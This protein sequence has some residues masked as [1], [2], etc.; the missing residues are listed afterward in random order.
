MLSNILLTC[1]VS[2]KSW[3]ANNSTQSQKSFKFSIHLQQSIIKWKLSIWFLKASY[4]FIVDS[5]AW[6]SL[7]CFSKKFI[8]IELNVELI[9]KSMI[10]MSWFQDSSKVTTTWRDVNWLSIQ[11]FQTWFIIWFK[12]S[13]TK[14]CLTLKNK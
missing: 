12:H 9:V 7:M 13:M 6:W 10:L 14:Y 8:I 5:T 11:F 1:K 3:D 2:L 4:Y